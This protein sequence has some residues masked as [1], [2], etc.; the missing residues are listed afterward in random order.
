MKKLLFPILVLVLACSSS[1]TFESTALCGDDATP[2]DTAPPTAYLDPTSGIYVPQ[3]AAEM[4]SL[5]NASPDHIWLVQETSGNLADSVGSADLAGVGTRLYQQTV[6]GWST[7]ALGTVYTTQGYWYSTDA[8]LPNLST[9]SQTY[10]LYWRFLSAPTSTQHISLN[11]QPGAGGGALQLRSDLDCKPV[12]YRGTTLG[13]MA[14][15]YCDGVVHALLV[16]YD[17]TNSSMTLV[18]ERERKVETFAGA[19]GTTFMLGGVHNLDQQFLAAYAWD[20]ANGELTAQEQWDL[21]DS[22]GFEMEW[23]R[24]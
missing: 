3:T 10:L 12:E 9:T 15:S 23:A 24:P 1:P 14:N 13:K 5:G 2:A 18:S 7:K 19:V 20:G 8:S 4:V 22:L 11:G 6:P 21:I 17:R 16:T